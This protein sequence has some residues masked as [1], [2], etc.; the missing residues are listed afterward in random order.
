MFDIWINASSLSSRHFWAES[1][2]ERRDVNLEF[3]SDGGSV[4]AEWDAKIW[5]RLALVTEMEVRN[6]VVKTGLV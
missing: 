2:S 5:E 3:I 6:E 4:G 1:R